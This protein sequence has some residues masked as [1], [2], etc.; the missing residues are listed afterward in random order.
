MAGV[1]TIGDLSGTAK[2]DSDFGRTNNYAANTM[3]FHVSLLDVLPSLT[4]ELDASGVQVLMENARDGMTAEDARK[5][6]RSL[7]YAPSPQ[8]VAVYD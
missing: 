5:L 4:S 3:E 6:L 1:G 2:F 8:N 7:R